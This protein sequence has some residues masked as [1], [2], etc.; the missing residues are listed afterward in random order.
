MTTFSALFVCYN[1][2]YAG[3]LK[4]VFKPEIK[5]EYYLAEPSDLVPK[6]NT[7]PLVFSAGGGKIYSRKRI[8]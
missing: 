1:I 5:D 6:E 7:S 4:Y 2:L 8:G 3:M